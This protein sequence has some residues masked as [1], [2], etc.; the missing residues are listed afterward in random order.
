MCNIVEQFDDLPC[1]Q[2]VK[3]LPNFRLEEK[4]LFLFVIM[5]LTF[6]FNS[7]NMVKI[8]EYFNN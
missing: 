7:L 2:V 1:H 4:G 5:F 8:Y 3:N 6:S